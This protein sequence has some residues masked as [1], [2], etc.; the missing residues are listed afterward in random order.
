[1]RVAVLLALAACGRF[2]F[3]GTGSGGDSAIDVAT[4]PDG[5]IAGPRW[6]QTI[7]ATD[8]LIVA[9]SGGSV[10][11]SVEFQGLVDAATQ[12]FSGQSQYM[13]TLVARFDPS[14]ALAAHT[15]L[16]SQGFC[17]MRAIAMQGDSALVVGYGLGG[18]AAW[19]PCDVMTTKE[20][21]LAIAIS[22]A[23]TPS[24]VSHWVASGQN[25]QITGVDPGS[26]GTLAVSGQ[27]G[28]DLTI[29]GQAVPTA[30]IDQNTFIARVDPS[31]QTTQ[32]IVAVASAS[33]NLGGPVAIDGADTC[34]SL[35]Y[36]GPVTIFGASVPF[37]AGYDLFVARVDATGQP[38]FA[39]A[40]STA[41]AEIPASILPTS[42]GG[43]LVSMQ[44][45]D[46]VIDSTSLPASGGPGALLHF[47][48]TGALVSGVRMPVVTSIVRAANGLYGAFTA[49]API[50]I[51]GT[52]Y[53]PAGSDV[54]VIALDESGP[55]AILGELAGAGDQALAQI[56]L[57]APDAIAIAALSTGAVAF[58]PYAGDSGS[59]TVSAIASFGL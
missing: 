46:L 7:S 12:P 40:L 16:D 26:D 39:R 6:L 20:D 14:G 53:T 56:A 45:G 18:N 23:G 55:T 9:G 38:K 44:A 2:G 3:D 11:A 27:Y 35:R 28:Q 36:E 51:G 43:C 59:A 5:G 10:V 22:S 19:G 24:L 4:I 21:P 1:V 33:Y 58:G 54:V 37:T 25:A 13:S 41:G 47:G 29:Y 42:D 57:I 8:S 31:A 50:T 34:I 17:N 48:P 52:T 49:A 32:W 15:V 30:G